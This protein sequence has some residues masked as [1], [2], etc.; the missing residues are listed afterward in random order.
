VITSLDTLREQTELN[1]I[2]IEMGLKVEKTKKIAETLQGAVET[3][4][5]MLTLC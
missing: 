5:T 1:Q 2:K 4:S 3:L